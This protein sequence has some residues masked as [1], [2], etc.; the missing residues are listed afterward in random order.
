MK[1]TL[2]LENNPEEIQSAISTLTLLLGKSEVAKAP[3][4]KAAEP[5]V[6]APV[7]TI[8]Q[9]V[10]KAAPAAA[11]NDT[12]ITD[13]VTADMIRGYVRKGSTAGLK[14]EMRELLKKYNAK[15]V[16]SLDNADYFNFYGELKTLVDG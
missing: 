12:V 8:T 3:V 14:V 7:K 9:P 16:T 15:D 1:I 13:E 5:V 2:S 6:K 4:V 11:K 10:E